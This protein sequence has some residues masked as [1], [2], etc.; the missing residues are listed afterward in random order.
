MPAQVLGLILAAFSAA[1][2]PAGGRP[3]S[4][5]FQSVRTPSFPPRRPSTI[6]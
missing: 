1:A 4:S 2:V 5:R 6:A 3:P